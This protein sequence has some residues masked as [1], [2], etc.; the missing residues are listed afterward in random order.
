MTKYFIEI[1]NRLILLFFTCFF[2]CFICYCYKET[3]LFLVI[4][5]NSVINKSQFYTLFYFIFTDVTE[6]FYVYIKLIVFLN[7]QF[8]LIYLIY[9][10]TI[11][12]TPAFFKHEYKV[13][14]FINLLSLTV[15][16]ISIFFSNFVIIPM[17]WNF[18]LNFQ[19]ISS[20]T[21]SLHLHF[22]AKLV[23]YLNFYINIYYSSY[24]YF[25]VFVI[26]ILFIGY[27][28]KTI[29]YLTFKKFRKFYY[30]CLVLL[31]T[32][33]TPPDVLSQLLLSLVF[34]LFLELVFICF[35]ARKPIKTD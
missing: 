18:F 12:F 23:E 34:I 24:L 32:L 21:Y 25:Q 26:V 11:F 15:W 29:T 17:T 1:K 14:Y 7:I 33:V 30:Y 20:R 13:I 5:P 8:F 9:H 28:S 35:L 3:L 31:S 2:S 19:D 6:V 16:I 4:Q 10:T 27:K 22:E